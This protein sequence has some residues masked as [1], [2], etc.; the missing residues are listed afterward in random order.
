MNS[1]FNEIRLDFLVESAKIVI[2]STTKHIVV[3]DLCKRLDFS[4]KIFSVYLCIFGKYGEDSLLGNTK[5][6]E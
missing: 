3:S 2:D 6:K 5:A 4:V 1:I